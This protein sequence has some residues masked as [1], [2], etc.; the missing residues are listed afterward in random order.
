MWI[1]INIHASTF[2]D[3]A[4]ATAGFAID[5]MCRNTRS[6]EHPGMEQQKRARLFL[7]AVSAIE[8]KYVWQR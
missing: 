4:Q 1:K 7:I 2:S 6:Q 8:N 3:A 5:E